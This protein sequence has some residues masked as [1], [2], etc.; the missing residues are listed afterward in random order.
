MPHVAVGSLI[1]HN[2]RTNFLHKIVMDMASPFRF[3]FLA[4]AE[5]S[6]ISES[7][8]ECADSAG[9]STLQPTILNAEVVN[10]VDSSFTWLDAECLFQSAIRKSIQ[11][12]SINI[13]GIKHDIF[14]RRTIQ[15]G[16]SSNLNEF[17]DSDLVCGVYEGGMKVW[18]CSVDMCRYFQENSVIIS[19]SVLE[20][21]CGHGLPGCWVLMKARSRGDEETIVTFSDFNEFVLHDAT[22]PNVILNAATDASLEQNVSWLSK[23][24][25]LGFGDWKN[26]S[27]QLT[28]R[29]SMESTL[30]PPS[31]PNS[32][33][34][35]GKFDIILA[36]ETT[37]SPEAA[38][39]TAAIISKHLRHNTG[40]AYI[41]T[42][43]Y[44]FGV[45]GGSDCFRE[46]LTKFSDPKNTTTFEVKTLAVFD[47]GAGNIREL[48]SVV[49]KGL[50]VN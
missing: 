13:S 32:L 42:K 31:L 7:K 5:D 49:Q 23:H 2:S 15:S 47:D 22:I 17:G 3:D 19:G 14:L 43:R 48:L 25:V 30:H 27:E 4:S 40:V 16:P 41:A 37:Y 38:R 11:H 9:A 45:G 44:Y 50:D 29:I 20:L 24:V 18:E 34:R 12:E 26:M 39:D 1:A 28:T 10:S 35:D 36:A 33:P 21:G 6:K 8:D 46:H